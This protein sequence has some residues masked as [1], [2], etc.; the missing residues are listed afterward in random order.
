MQVARLHIVC[1]GFL[2]PWLTSARAAEITP[3]ASLGLGVSGDGAI[4]VGALDDGSQLVATRWASADGVQHLGQGTAYDISRDGATIVGERLVGSMQRS[5]RWNAQQGFS[6][7]GSLAGGNNSSHARDVSSDGGVVVGLAHQA[8]GFRGFRWT[9]QTGMVALGDLPG[10]LSFS[11]ANSISPDGQITVGVSTGPSGDRA[12]RWIGASTIPLDMGLPPG[13]TG[14]TEAK[15]VSGD[16]EVVVG[17]WSDGL[18]S[19]EAFRWTSLGGYELLGD[20]P[21]GLLDSVATQAN[22][23]GSVIVGTGNLGDDVPDEAFYWT[24]SSGMR[25][26]RDVMQDAGADLSAWRTLDAPTSLSDDGSVIVG[27]GTLIDGTVAGFRAVVAVPEPRANLLVFISCATLL[28][29]RSNPS[30]DRD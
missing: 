5:F 16:G 15:G 6:D 14:F 20:F 11:Q 1:W 10:G 13:L 25:T 30:F 9:S 26:L 4:V 28:A 8:T 12:V 2:I 27:T 3:I 21:G 7:L 18:F 17:V 23:D 19:N 24:A 29:R 22:F